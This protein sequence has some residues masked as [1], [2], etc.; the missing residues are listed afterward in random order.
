MLLHAFADEDVARHPEIPKCRPPELMVI[1][2]P[3]LA[4]HWGLENQAMTGLLFPQHRWRRGRALLPIAIAALLMTIASQARP[5]AEDDVLQQAINYVFTGSTDP[6][7]S[8]E[9]VDRKSCVVVVPEPKFKRFARYYLGRFK[10]DLSRISKKY[11]GHDVSYELEVEGDGVVLEFL[12]SD[13]TTV[14]YGFKSAHIALPGNIDRT[15]KALALIFAEYCK[16]EKPKTP[17]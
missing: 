13:K 6:L 10:M 16:V 9:I 3:R 17:F 11:S 12:K 15:Q 14:D 1:W 8:P 2:I 5:A 7:D 4:S